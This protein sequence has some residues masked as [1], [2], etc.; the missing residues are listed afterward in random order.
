MVHSGGHSWFTLLGAFSGGQSA[1]KHGEEEAGG[2]AFCA[3]P[4]GLV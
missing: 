2:K 1:N 3:C 4:M